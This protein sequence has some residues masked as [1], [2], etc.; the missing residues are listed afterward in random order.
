[1]IQQVIDSSYKEMSRV[2]NT[3][4]DQPNRRLLSY[5]LMMQDPAKNSNEAY[6][7]IKNL[8]VKFGAV[9]NISRS[10]AFYN[11]LYNAQARIPEAI[12][13]TDQADFFKFLLIGYSQGNE[14]VNPDW[15]EFTRRYQRNIN[16]FI[17]YIDENN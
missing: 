13:G 2:E 11:D 8:P 17:L 5:A 7:L 12:S 6:L 16:A 9:Q 15:N 3:T 4:G 1:M 10:F 14:K